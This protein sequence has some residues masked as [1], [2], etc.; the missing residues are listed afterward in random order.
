[1]GRESKL[2]HSRLCSAGPLD[3]GVK[4][5]TWTMLTFASASATAI[6]LPSLVFSVL[7]AENLVSRDRFFVIQAYAPHG[8]IMVGRVWPGTPSIQH[9]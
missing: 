9:I 8:D 3:L 7:L 6:D 5:V 2:S 1:M 4:F